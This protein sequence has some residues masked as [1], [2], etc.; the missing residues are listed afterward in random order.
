MAPTGSRSHVSVGGWRRGMFLAVTSL[1]D[2][3]GLRARGSVQSAWRSRAGTR[4]RCGCVH[5]ATTDEFRRATGSLAIPL[6]PFAASTR[7]PPPATGGLAPAQDVALCRRP[8]EVRADRPAP[9]CVNRHFVLGQRANP[10]ESAA[11]SPRSAG[12]LVH[13]GCQDGT[14][15]KRQASAEVHRP[16]PANELFKRATSSRRREAV[17]EA[18]EE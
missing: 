14:A 17:S 7:W 5:T 8:R 6:A 1:N 11:R 15:V 2:S 9:W 3:S 18:L 16:P 12:D 4:G 13:G 10:M